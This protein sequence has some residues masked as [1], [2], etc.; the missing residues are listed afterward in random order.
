MIRSDL[1]RR[2]HLPY[3]HT[4]ALLCPLGP[5]GRS[6]RARL[7]CRRASGSTFLCNPSYVLPD[8][9]SSGG[10]LT[11]EGRSQGRGLYRLQGPKGSLNR[12]LGRCR[13]LSFLWL[14]SLSLL[15]A[16]RS[17]EGRWRPRSPHLWASPSRSLPPQVGFVALDL[18]QGPYSAQAA[19]GVGLGALDQLLSSAR[20]ATRILTC[21]QIS[22]WFAVVAPLEVRWAMILLMLAAP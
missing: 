4:R 13:Y 6:H 8:R 19:L 18:A 17:G 10:C 3:T 15:G 5:P 14:G 1:P 2:P 7:G 21:P 11:K 9:R 22:V 20:T 12:R 16:A